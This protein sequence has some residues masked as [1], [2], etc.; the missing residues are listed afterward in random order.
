MKSGAGDEEASDETMSKEQKIQWASDMVRAA[1]GAPPWGMPESIAKACQRQA[2]QK[3]R[4]IRLEPGQTASGSGW[5]K[6]VELSERDSVEAALRLIEA[7]AGK[8]GVLVFGS[9][10]R[11]GGGWLNGASAQEEDVSRKTT[12]ALG[13]ESP[14]FHGIEHADPIYEDRIVEVEGWAIAK[15]S[16]G[17][18]E[19]LQAPRELALAGFAAPN[20]RAWKEQGRSMAEGNRRAE[21]ALERRCAQ[22]LRSFESMGA[23]A[24]VIGAIGCGVFQVDPKL[25]AKAWRAALGQAGGSLKIIECALGPSPSES[26]KEAFKELVRPW[27]KA[28]RAK[29][30]AKRG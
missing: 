20:M 18:L 23:Q 29:P 6:P 15:E 27:E 30:G 4:V 25:A 8:V 22:A 3:P 14:E 17:R 13:C 10:R 5:S 16:F 11:P 21:A 7:G 19:W 24:A 28:S 2:N 9:A 26:L 1:E 12:W